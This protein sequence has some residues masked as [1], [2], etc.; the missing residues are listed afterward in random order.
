MVAAYVE[1]ERVAFNR[2]VGLTDVGAP[3][4]PVPEGEATGVVPCS[5]RPADAE[6]C[7]SF[8]RSEWKDGMLSLPDGRRA[9]G[10][11]SYEKTLDAHDAGMQSAHTLLLTHAL[12]PSVRAHVPGFQEMEA[13]LA[14]WLHERFGSVV[15]LFYCHGLRQSPHTLKSTGFDVH[16]D[17]EDFD[18]I[19]YTV[20]VKLTADV[21]GEPPSQMRVVGCERHFDYGPAA[22]SSGLFRARLFHASVAPRSEREHLKLAFFFRESAPPL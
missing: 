10:Y 15:E 18:F 6:A 9:L 14:S 8:L 1:E 5:V 7:A 16:Q 19:E 3:N 12:L 21:E 11:A 2:K 20:V 17:T 4:P 13:T 22:G